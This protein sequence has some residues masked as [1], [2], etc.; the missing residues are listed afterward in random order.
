MKILIL[1]NNDTGLYL[2]RRELITELLKNNDVIIVV[3]HGEYIENLIAMGCRHINVKLDRRTINVYKDTKLFLK[4]IKLIKRQNAD[5]VITYTIKPNI[6]GGFACSILKI[7]YYTNIT[8]LGTAFQK[9]GVL[10]RLVTGMYKVSL[11]KAKVV[12]FENNDNRQIFVDNNIININKTH[13]LMGAG[14]NLEHFQIQKYP[15]DDMTRFIFIGRIMKEKGV[16]ELF[17]AAEKLQQDGLKF[18]IDMIGDLEEEYSLR[19]ASLEEK[20]IVFYHGYKKDVR[21]FI[22]DSHCGVLPSWHEGMAN[23]NLECAASGRPII[24][25]NIAGCKEAVLDNISGYLCEVRNSKS[26]YIMM[27]KFVC[28]PYEEKK[29]MGINGRQLMTNK[30]DKR[31]VV[32]ETIDRMKL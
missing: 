23:A 14:V 2:F 11:R 16:D 28:L 7:P 30:F 18:R 27:K 22:I 31:M 15:E 5:A 1:S 4:Y 10:K 17:E 6:Y 21:P 26:L 29:L 13:V 8:G 24:T 9:Q 20:G 3:P 25:S 32:R 19:M 12:F